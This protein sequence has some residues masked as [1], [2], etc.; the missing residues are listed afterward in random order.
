MKRITVTATVIAAFAIFA[1]HA[2]ANPELSRTYR[3]GSISPPDLSHSAHNATM[4]G[5]NHGRASY[6]I[7]IVTPPGRAGVEPELSFAYH[8]N[9]RE[10]VLGTGWG[11][12]VPKI[13]V[14]TSGRGGQPN[15]GVSAR[16]LGLGGQE[17]VE[18]GSTWPDMDGDG[19]R[20]AIYREEYDSTYIRYRQLSD[21]GWQVDFPDGRKLTLGTTSDTRI[22]RESEP[23][24]VVEWLPESMVDTRDN[25]LIWLWSTPQD[26]AQAVG[27][28]AAGENNRYLTELRWGCQDCST[29]AAYQSAR[30]D[31]EAL[32]A[33]VLDF[34][35]G[36]LRE[37][38]FRIAQIVTATNSGGSESPVRTYALSYDDSDTRRVL[39]QVSVSGAD[40]STLPP[41][42]FR[43]TSRHA[44]STP[45]AVTAPPGVQFGAGVRAIDVDLDGSP[46]VA[47]LSNVASGATYFRHAV[48]SS[49]AFE[50]GTA[51]AQPGINLTASGSTSAEDAT[52][53][54]AIDVFD[55]AGGTLYAHDGTNGWDGVGVQATLPPIVASGDTVRHDVNAD[56]YPDLL[57]TSVSP[58]ELW[59]DDGSLTF[60]DDF[61]TLTD[62]T[63]PTV[64]APLN[65]TADGLMFGE[66][67]GDGLVDAVYI[68]SGGTSAYVYFSRGRGGFGWV[69]EDDR[70]S[71][72]ATYAITS[73]GAAPSRGETVVS[74]IDGDGLGDLVSFDSA[75][76]RLRVWQRVP[77][78]GYV[79]AP[80]GSPFTQTI[81]S[82]RGCIP[83]DWDRDGVT[84][85]M[86]SDGWQLYD[87]A[88]QVP[89]MLEEVDNG[90]GMVTRLDY[91]TTAREAA[92][93]ESAGAPWHSNVSMAMPVVAHLEVDDSRGNVLVS[94]YHYRDAR[95]ETDALEDRFE[96]MGFGYVSTE[97]LA[98]VETTAGDEATR[99]HDPQDPGALLRTHYDTG[100]SN[101]FRRGVV[102]CEETYA[103][104][105]E[106][107][108][109][110]CDATE[111]GALLRVVQSHSAHMD[112]DGITTVN[113]DAVDRYSI[114]GGDISEAT[115]TREEY[116][117]DTFGNRTVHRRFGTSDPD[118][119]TMTVTDFVRNDDQWIV[120]LPRLVQKGEMLLSGSD[121]T[122][123]MT[124]QTCFEYDDVSVLCDEGYDGAADEHTSKGE[125]TATYRYTDDDLADSSP[126]LP[127]VVERRVYSDRGLP[128]TITDGALVQTVIEYDADFGLFEAARTLDPA[129]LALHTTTTVAPAHGETLRVDAP[130]GTTT[131]ARY[132]AL[133]R[134]T[135]HVEPGDSLASPT[136][137]WAYAH[138]APLSTVATTSKDGTPDGLTTTQYLDGAGRVLCEEKEATAGLD[139]TMQR[140]LTARGLPAI[141][142]LPFNGAGCD[143]A[144]VDALGRSSARPHDASL[145]DPLGRRVRV[146]H[147]PEGSFATKRYAPLHVTSYDEE[148]NNPAGLHFG[149][150]THEFADGLGR[151]ASVVE[152]ADNDGDG[153]AEW[154]ETTYTYDSLG[155]IEVTDPLGAT[156]YEAAHDS[157]GRVVW[158][159]A[160]DRGTQ[161]FLYDNMDRTTSVVDAREHEL[162]YTYDAA[163]RVLAVT[164]DDGATLD[165]TTYEYDNH[166]GGAPATS[167]CNTTGRLA[168]VVD[169][170]GETNFCYDKRGRV[171]R[172]GTTID[173]HSG[174]ELVTRTTFDKQDRVQSM[175]HPDG[176]RLRYEYDEGGRAHRL[177]VRSNGTDY[178]LVSDAH[179][180]A[181]GSLTQ[182][183]YGN[184]VVVDLA[185]DTRLRPFRTSTGGAGAG[186][187][188]LT[189]GLD[190]TGNVASIDDAVGARSGSFTYDD[191][192]RLTVAQG[193]FVSGN[194]L[195]YTYDPRGNQSSR[196]STDASS[197]MN[198]SAFEY[199]DADAV[200]A[201]TGIDRDG[202]G[203]TD[204]TFDYDATG[205]LKTDG[206]HAFRYDAFG[207]LVAV[208]ELS[209]APLAEY[210]Y[211]YLQRRVASTYTSG[212]EVF[213]VHPANAQIRITGGTSVTR[214]HI[215]FAGRTIAVLEDTFSAGT[216]ADHL[217]VYVTDHLGQPALVYDIEASPSIVERWASFPFGAENPGTLDDEGTSADYFP[218]DDSASLLSRRFQG[219]EVDSELPALYDFG[220]RI[221]RSDLGRFMSADTVIPELTDAQSWNR[222][223]F[224]RNNPLSRIDPSGHS[225]MGA[226]APPTAPHC[227]AD[228]PTG[229][230]VLD[231]NVRDLQ[232]M[233][234]ED[235]GPTATAQEPDAPRGMSQQEVLVRDIGRLEAIRKGGVFTTSGVIVHGFGAADDPILRAADGAVAALSGTV[236]PVRPL[237]H[238]TAN[239]STVRREKWQS[240]VITPPARNPAPPRSAPAPERPTMPGNAP[241]AS[242]STGQRWFRPGDGLNQAGRVVPGD[243]PSSTGGAVSTK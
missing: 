36:F 27:A 1:G 11:L 9:H 34:A 109:F 198:I 189:L 23:D 30:I 135:K 220:A 107:T 121:A 149:T 176:T 92:A 166:P 236:R 16:Y 137:T 219:R 82:A 178:T 205:N 31:Y 204:E 194:S 86:C 156:V 241:N 96:F 206:S 41:T 128:T 99:I 153:A 59:L 63:T 240:E 214:K 237:A 104:G 98:Y 44:P 239:T 5:I 191:W 68:D 35:P 169:E 147:E 71:Q 120:R 97:Q 180:N 2:S 171:I 223:S 142:Y 67:N 165:L 47:D 78:S 8:G 61:V 124:Q 55:L 17:L 54:I 225:D 221:Y 145:N 24:D 113:L 21:G 25:E 177:T 125:R 93:A 162:A 193:D 168:Q 123:V 50:T 139:V 40:G 127:I 87:W 233:P 77:G 140:E 172:E 155:L 170:A 148:D 151:I 175:T 213:F 232:P 7:E 33:H 154:Y 238:P 102:L 212:D 111:G 42:T 164:A 65:A 158:T 90:A 95:L 18:L 117:Y 118:D 103:R 126:G 45:A 130:D 15:Y 161:D 53:N 231:F 58:W 105:D 66:V 43:Y 224:V 218:P 207:M 184:G 39:T 13:R 76:G 20:E 163:G 122:F 202:D 89:F 115:H 138:G 186:D 56:G 6:S 227:T 116:E 195:T 29:A 167:A 197:S 179:Y 181:A 83:A 141:E 38:E 209:G 143:T 80:T 91:T 110:D 159:N 72:Y 196:S 112:A 133:G 51:T 10:T 217:H 229:T 3:D 84:E 230:T 28:A 108:D 234:I 26:V 146:T 222:Y 57:D 183:A 243:S 211:D 75:A 100:T 228:N 119:Q 182:L 32:P 216:E 85:V 129:G 201:L 190:S 73:I 131:R 4:V 88:D 144:T 242:P 52:R 200:H 235:N 134:M 226:T 136:T 60:T 49:V 150:P 81:T 188:D 101:F 22:A 187:F 37:W 19:E 152:E 79:E 208:E 160:E 12:T 46:D 94:S 157:R 74:D 64:S 199:S 114:E 185:Y 173:E 14:R 69:P 215:D 48:G 203:T 106:P 62:A 210:T 70:G 132:D 192:G 174:T